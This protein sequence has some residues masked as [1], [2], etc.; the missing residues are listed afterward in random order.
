MAYNH[1]FACNITNK[2]KNAEK[3]LSEQQQLVWQTTNE[4]YWS[5]IFAFNITISQKCNLYRF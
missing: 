1:T 3:M 4:K 2:L 5:Y